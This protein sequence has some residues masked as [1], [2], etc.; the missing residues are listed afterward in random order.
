LTSARREAH[1]VIAMD[2]AR[3]HQ[4]ALARIALI[5]LALCAELFGRSLSHRLNFGQHVRTP[6]Y[7]GADYYPVLLA[8]VKFGV[9]LMLA[10]LAW[11]FVKAT[12][13][14]Q[15]SGGGGG[16]HRPLPPSPQQILGGVVKKKNLYK[17]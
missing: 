9:A 2:R 6:S 1:T 17:I 15:S 16:A 8:V 4:R 13:L 10:R 14:L 7:S 3:R 12:R 5:F 11:R